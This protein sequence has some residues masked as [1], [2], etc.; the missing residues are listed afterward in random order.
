MQL[1]AKIAEG[2]AWCNGAMLAVVL[3]DWLCFDDRLAR[4]GAVLLV[5]LER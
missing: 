2:F 3:A 5:F 1:L 4:L